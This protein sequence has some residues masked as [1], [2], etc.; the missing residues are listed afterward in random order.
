MK[1][2]SEKRLRKIVLESHE[3]SAVYGGFKIRVIDPSLFPW[4]HLFDQCIEISQDV[5]IYKK[6]DKIYISFKPGAL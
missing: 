5:W 3:V 4:Y 2:G 6:A 1:M